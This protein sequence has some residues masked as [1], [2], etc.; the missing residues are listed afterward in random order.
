MIEQGSDAWKRQRLGKA[1][2]SRIADVIARTK[3]GYGASRESYKA[4]LVLERLT[5]Q[6]RDFFQT[7]AMLHG[8]TT[9]PEACNAYAFHCDA[10]LSEVG[11]IDH[12]TIP[13][14]GASPDRLVSSDGML[15]AK[16][17]QPNTHLATLLNGK[18]PEKYRTQILWQLACMPERKWADFISYCA[19]FPPTM[20]LFVQRIDRDDE[21]IAELEREVTEFLAEVDNT[22]G[23]LLAAYE[24]EMEA[25]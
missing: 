17:P 21:A 10:E 19:D 25:A 11:F 12:P 7:A 18:V 20:R 24:P 22:V 6:P 3:S 1:T 15:E 13:M 14:S 8:I 4:D 16:C 23:K 9:E 5:G 2:A